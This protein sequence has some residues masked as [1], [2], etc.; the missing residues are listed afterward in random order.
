MRLI[1]FS[2]TPSYPS[3]DLY[4]HEPLTSAVHNGVHPLDHRPFQPS[5][6]F[7]RL[8]RVALDDNLVVAHEDR[9][10]SAHPDAPGRV[11]S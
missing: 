4:W 2:P 1:T 6:C 5:L 3:L 11:G 10:V 7:S 8:V 9:G